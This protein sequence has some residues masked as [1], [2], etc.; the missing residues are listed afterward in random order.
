[1]GMSERVEPWL[2]CRSRPLI[3]MVL[4]V[5]FM[6]IRFGFDYDF[7]DSEASCV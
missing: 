5:V 2:G 3:A 7:G 6:V 1:M 4:F